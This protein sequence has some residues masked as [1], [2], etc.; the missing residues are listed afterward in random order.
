MAD[1][2]DLKIAD[3]GVAF[4]ADMTSLEYLGL[5]STPITREAMPPL[6]RMTHLRELDVRDIRDI[7]FDGVDELGDPM[8]EADIVSR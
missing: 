1:L 7:S 8:P 3:D 4:P 6:T 5:G 2:T